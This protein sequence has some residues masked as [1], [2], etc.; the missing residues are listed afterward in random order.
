[1]FIT[2]ITINAIKVTVQYFTV[3]VYK[4]THNPHKV[5]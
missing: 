4:P 2:I 1:M 3:V 5:V